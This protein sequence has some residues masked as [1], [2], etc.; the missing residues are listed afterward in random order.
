MTSTL[1]NKFNISIV[2]PCYNEEKNIDE[3]YERMLRSI[4]K[5]KNLRYEIIFIDDGSFDYTWDKIKEITKKNKFIKGI[6]LSKNFGHQ[7]AIISSFE[8]ISGNYILFIDTD[9]EHPPELLQDMIK[10]MLKNSANV[11]YALKNKRRDNLLKK[12][13]AK[14]FYFLFNKLSN[15]KI[16][17]NSN[18]FRLMDKK[19]FNYLKKFKEQDPF[20][21]GLI[22]WSGFKQIPIYYDTDTRRKRKSG[23]TLSKMFN[24]SA[25]AFFGFSVYPMRISFMISIMLT[26]VFLAFGFHAIYTYVQGNNIPGWTSIFL[27]IILF[28]IFQFFI[29]GLISEYTGRVYMEVKNRP[30][31]IIDEIIKKD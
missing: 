10:T 31:Y 30:R 25:S 2:A 15:T 21:R 22:T 3:F 13:S 24:F 12:Y 14:F 1:I 17:V 29:L 16:P 4:K 6:K 7:N 11:V 28:N 8:I 18:E 23:W 5:I 19:V 9:L 27:L 26:L 20:L